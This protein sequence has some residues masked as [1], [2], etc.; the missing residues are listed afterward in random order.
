MVAEQRLFTRMWS[1]GRGHEAA[2]DAKRSAMALSAS[3]AALCEN[4]PL[5]QYCSNA[6][7]R[8][9]AMASAERPSIW[10]R[11]SMNA[12]SPSFSS[13]MEGDDGG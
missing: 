9:W 3:S 8:S 10:W 5:Q 13:A 4:G 1:D 2:E 11:S 7:A 6:P 12:T